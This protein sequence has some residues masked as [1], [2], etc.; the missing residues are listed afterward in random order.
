MKINCNVSLVPGQENQKVSELQLPIKLKRQCAINFEVN[1]GVGENFHGQNVLEELVQP[2][3][4]DP[5]LRFESASLGFGYATNR[6]PAGMSLLST[7][8]IGLYCYRN[9][10][11]EY[12]ERKTIKQL[13]WN[14]SGHALGREMLS[15]SRG[16]CS[17]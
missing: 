17:F 15:Y 8:C 6:N 12:F 1:T 9:A 4:E 10:R 7:R 5:G 14:I 13:I 3:L 11:P 16:K 2:V